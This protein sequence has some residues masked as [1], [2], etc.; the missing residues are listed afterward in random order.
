MSQQQEY[1]NIS[2]EQDDLY[3][4]VYSIDGKMF[5]KSGRWMPWHVTGYDAFLTCGAVI[6]F[7]ELEDYLMHGWA[8]PCI[9]F[10]ILRD[11]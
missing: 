7:A 2:I 10:V 1:V 11:L 5:V 4:Y 3:I 9:R 8:N 6:H